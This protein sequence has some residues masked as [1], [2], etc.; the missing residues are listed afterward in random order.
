MNKVYFLLIFIQQQQQHQLK[1]ISVFQIMTR[2]TAVRKQILDAYYIFKKDSELK[3]LI[4][5]KLPEKYSSVF[6]LR[7]LLTD[8]EKF[9]HKNILFDEA[10]IIRDY[11]LEE[12]DGFDASEEMKTSSDLPPSSDLTKNNREAKKIRLEC[13]VQRIKQNQ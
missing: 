9:I 12:V 1:I 2:Q 6:T 4:Q 13:I 5:E 11:N 7:N 3:K 8:M 10:I